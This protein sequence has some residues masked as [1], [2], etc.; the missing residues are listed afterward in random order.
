MQVRKEISDVL[1]ERVFYREQLT[2]LQ[3]DVH[4]AIAKEVTYAEY[5][6][7]RMQVT[8]LTLLSAR[9]QA[10]GYQRR[11]FDAL[12]QARGADVRLYLALWGG[13]LMGGFTIYLIPTLA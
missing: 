9:E 6:S 11:Y 2:R 8:A 7:L 4:P 12:W 10:L 5:W 1:A 3:D 13:E